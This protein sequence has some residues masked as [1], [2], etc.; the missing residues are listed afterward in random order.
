MGFTYPKTK[1]NLQGVHGSESHMSNYCYCENRLLY[2]W[3][4]T[5]VKP[6]WFLGLLGNRYILYTASSTCHHT[7]IHKME[8]RDSVSDFFIYKSHHLQLANNQSIPRRKSSQYK[9]YLDVSKLWSR[10]ICEGREGGPDVAAKN[11]E[12]IWCWWHG[13]CEHHFL[14]LVRWEANESVKHFKRRLL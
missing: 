12:G 7:C 1:L 11:K 3:K 4:P 5:S 13:E 14:S 8:H 2:M 9:T 10:C 6:L